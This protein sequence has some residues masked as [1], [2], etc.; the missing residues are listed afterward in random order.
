VVAEG[1]A[2]MNKRIIGLALGAALI[3][4]PAAEASPQQAK[5]IASLKRQVTTL[6]AAN[7][8]LR[9]EYRILGA[10]YDTLVQELDRVEDEAATKDATINTLTG[11]VASLNAALQGKIATDVNTYLASQSP[12]QLWP[13]LGII[14]QRFN[15]TSTVFWATSYSGSGGYRSYDFTYSP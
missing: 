6:K 13:V 5:Q 1:E 12:A 2:A 11:Q 8:N 9:S 3:I 10:D 15:T 4:A 14:Y 7:K